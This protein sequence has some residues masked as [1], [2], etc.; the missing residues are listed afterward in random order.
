VP[1]TRQLNSTTRL[2]SFQ[3]RLG[4][5]VYLDPNAGT[6]RLTDALVA[7]G[8]RL[9]LTYRP[10]IFRVSETASASSI[11][12]SIQYDYRFAG[13]IPAAAQPGGS[14]FRVSGGTLSPAVVPDAIRTSRLLFT[15]GR[16][17]TGAGQGARPFMRTM[18][19]GIQLP[20]QIHVQGNGNPTGITV[21]GLPAGTFVEID[22]V[23]GR[24]YVTDTAE[25][26]DSVTVQYVS[27][28]PVTG[29]PGPAIS[30]TY[31]IGVVPESGEAPVPM[32]NAQNESSMVTILD[33][34]NPAPASTSVLRPGLVWMFWTSTRN[35]F[36]DVYF[37]TLAPRFSA[38]PRQ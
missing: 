16:L 37:Q 35:G 8:N 5:I 15:Y 13:N 24:L 33:P 17:A 2:V 3:S 11:N 38:Q 32:T 20:Q 23:N 36:P 12:P 21:N 18:R 25:F 22:P 29:N 10:R 27:V 9:M 31:A 1:D 26:A 4:G 6:V 28:D 34:I 14:W 7:Q 19:F 30:G